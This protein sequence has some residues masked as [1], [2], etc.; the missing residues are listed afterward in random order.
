MTRSG[1]GTTGAA[2][3]GGGILLK[4]T[5]GGGIGWDEAAG[6]L[7]FFEAADFGLSSFC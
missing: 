3:G 7:L 2:T 1:S 6:F 5:G 4:I